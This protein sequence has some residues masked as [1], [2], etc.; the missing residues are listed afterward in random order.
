MDLVATVSETGSVDVWRFNGQ[1]VFGL[2]PEEGQGQAVEGL[3]WKADGRLLA[4]ALASGS[5][6]LL[7]AF[8]GKVA[9]RFPPTTSSTGATTLPDW[10]TASLAAPS[11]SSPDSGKGSTLAWL[12]HSTGP[13]PKAQGRPSEASLGDKSEASPGD[14]INEIA[15]AD[16]PRALSSVD[17]ES[18]LPKLSTL[19]PTGADDDIFSSRTAIDSV[20]HSALAASSSAGAKAGIIDLLLHRRLQTEVSVRMFDSFDIGSIDLSSVLPKGLAITR[21]LATVGH[22]LLPDYYFVVEAEPDGVLTRRSDPAGHK[23]SLQLLRV[24][25]LLL[26]HTSK[27]LPLLAAKATQLQNLLRYLQQ[28]QAQLASEVRTAFDLPRRFLANLNETLAV[29]GGGATFRTTAYHLI[30]TGECDGRLKEWLVDDVGDRGLKRWE[31]AVGDCL[32]LMRRMT[33]ECLLPAVERCQVVLSRL[34]GLARFDDTASRLGLSVDDIR[35]IRETFDALALLCEDMLRDVCI[36]TREF[37]AFIKWLKWE[38]EVEGF[39]EDSERAEEMREA[40]AGEAELRTVM[41]YIDGPVNNSRILAYVEASGS[42]NADTS[43]PAQIKV[44]GNDQFYSNFKRQ[45]Q[46]RDQGLPKLGALIQRLRSST[47]AFLHH[48]A[49]SLRKSLLLSHVAELPNTGGKIECR[50]FRSTTNVEQFELHIASAHHAEGS[51]IWHTR[52]ALRGNP[53]ISSQALRLPSLYRVYDAKWASDGSLIVLVGSDAK[54]RGDAEQQLKQAEEQNFSEYLSILS[55]ELGNNASSQPVRQAAGLALKNAFTAKDFNRLRTVQGRWL[56]VVSPE[57]K[58]KVRKIAL[59]TL[60]APGLAAASAAQLI[61]AIAAIELPRYEWPDLMTTLVS[62]VAEGDSNVKQS[63]LTTIG[64]ICES[65]DMDLR[66]TLVGQSNAILTAVVQGARKE[67]PDSAVRL[68]ALT[69]LSDATEFIRSNFDNEA[70]RNY[71]MQVVCEATQGPDSAVKAAAF[72][73][74]NRIM[75]IFYDKMSFYMQRALFGLTV[76]GMKSPEEDVAKL[77]IEFWCTVCEEEISIDDDNQQAQHEGSTELVRPFFQFAKIAAKEVVPVLLNLLTQVDEDDADDEYNTARAAYQCLQLYAQT[78]GGDIVPIVLVFVEQNIR[79]QD[80]RQRDAA[81][82]AFG[83]IMDGPDIKI[84]DP[85]VKQALPILIKTMLEDKQVQVQDSAAYALSRI[86]DYCAECIDPSEHLPELMEALFRGLESNP[87]IASSCCLAL[88]NLTERF[89][90]DGNS[91]PNQLT[92]YFEQSVSLLLTVT[93]KPDGNQQVRT[94]A[95]EV[96]GSFIA[97]CA[98]ESKSLFDKL[99]GE[100][101]QRLRSTIPYQQQ[102]VSIED[103]MTLDEL[104]V[105]LA[106][107]LL[108]ILQRLESDVS[109]EMADAI[110]RISLEL[111]KASSTTNVPEVV[112]QIASALANALLGGFE[113]YMDDFVPY[114]YNALGNHEAPDMCSLAIGLVSDIVRALEGKAQRFCDT[115]MNYLLQ[116]LASNKISNQLK[117]PI[118]ETFGDIATSIGPAFEPYAQTVATVLEQARTV[119]ASGDVSLDLF[120]YVVSLRSG[121]ADAWGGMILAFKRTDKVFVLQPFLQNIFQF[122]ETVANDP[123]HNEGLL[124]ACMGIIGDLGEAFPDG[125]LADFFRFEYVTRLIRETRAARDSSERT[126]EAARWARQIVKVQT[127]KHQGNLMNPLAQQHFRSQPLGSECIIEREARFSSEPSPAVASKLNWEDRA[128]QTRRRKRVKLA[129]LTLFDPPVFQP[130]YALDLPQPTTGPPRHLDPY[131][132]TPTFRFPETLGQ[133]LVTDLYISKYMLDCKQ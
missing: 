91:T 69:A 7:D 123:N 29:E 95:Y 102:I 89:A 40:F 47:D 53:P 78:I 124:R 133:C 59:Q 1:R 111:L 108:C 3:A 36:E 71:I 50:I 48:V 121:I 127:T 20:F 67:E 9:H 125:Q 31:K 118:L 92:K 14:N 35:P 62:N 117:P 122:L 106:S 65:E 55:S 73:C 97:N 109:R 113:I 19:P 103:K 101:I 24:Q 26:N 99:A 39:G 81:V 8:T 6:I 77:A 32:D 58:D 30:V 75:G 43:T 25:L 63:S 28:I 83:A 45:R 86:C 115:F 56:Q 12:S 64:F 90:G 66:E 87:K 100:I 54:I 5:V 131:P 15:T 104:Q 105:S 60:H 88:L 98:N 79:G 93:A 61:A 128:E 44:K 94:A 17:L 22:P 46:K 10:S 84:L 82:S 129:C 74:L 2:L 76:G 41:D 27:H 38:A 112:F 13:Q 107:V 80:W 114:L 16:L 49:E 96:L 126:R 42:E 110:M 34:E 132:S 120:D 4:V 52:A 130:M 70:E 51:G 21:T 57:I 11:P 23:P 116:A 72:G 37:S 33:S 85:L 119:S 18:S 68:A